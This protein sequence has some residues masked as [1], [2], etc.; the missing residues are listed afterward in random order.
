MPRVQVLG[1]RRLCPSHPTPDVPHH[2]LNLRLQFRL[3]AWS[4]GC[5]LGV[6][7]HSMR[8]NSRMLIVCAVVA[9]LVGAG[10]ASAINLL[11]DYTYDTSNF[12]GNGNPQGATAGLQAK[13]ALEA[14][15]TFFSGIL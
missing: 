3:E 8:R 9:L 1:H 14:A 15:A 5:T 12:F 10:R 11:V 13:S 4:S 7:R 2:W 6:L